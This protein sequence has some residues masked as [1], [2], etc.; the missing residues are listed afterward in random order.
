MTWYRDPDVLDFDARPQAAR[1]AGW[2]RFQSPPGL[3]AM[4]LTARGTV[5]AWVDG[6][7]QRVERLDRPDRWRVLVTEPSLECSV[8]ALRLQQSRGCYGGAALPDPIEL[9]CGPGRIELGDW[10]QIDGLACYSGGAWYRNTVILTDEQAAGTV[11]LDLGHV[12]SSAEVRVNG[13]P[14]GVR[15]AP[16]WTVDVTPLIRTGVNR[17]E[18]LVYNTLANHYQTIPTRYRGSPV[19]G[20]LGPVRVVVG[21]GP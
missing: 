20:L 10:S 16:P 13:R 17:I 19:S 15:V 9:D 18:I 1:P 3:R 4:T 7:E 2:Y 12:V 5:Q 21:R 8:V 11:T 6:Q 14:A